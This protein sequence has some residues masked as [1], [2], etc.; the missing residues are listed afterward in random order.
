[1]RDCNTA[2]ASFSSSNTGGD[3]Y[4]GF[5]TEAPASYTQHFPFHRSFHFKFWELNVEPSMEEKRFY[6]SIS[7]WAVVEGTFFSTLSYPSGRLEFINVGSPGSLINTVTVLKTVIRRTWSPSFVYWDPCL[8]Y[9]CYHDWLVSDCGNK[10]TILC[11][12]PGPEKGEISMGRDSNPNCL[13][14]SK[15]FFSFLSN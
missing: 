14:S 6:Y 3:N 13:V 9:Q 4:F 12:Y 7:Q 1:M 15:D 5:F 11:P 2:I 8:L 10:H